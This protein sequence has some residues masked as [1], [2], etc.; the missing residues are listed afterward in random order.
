MTSGRPVH[1]IPVVYGVDNRFAAPLAASI[2]SAIAH[3]GSG[4][5]LAI[6][7]VDGGLTER[8][9]GRL[10]RSFEG[11]CTLSW[12]RPNVSALASLKVGGAITVATYY[13]LLIPGLLP[14]HAKAI[15]LDADVIVEHDLAELWEMA[16][17]D[18]HVLAAQDQGVRLVSGPYGLSNYRELGIPTDAKYFNAG[19][20]VLNL[21]RWRRDATADDILEYVLRHPEH[22]RFHD[23]DGLNAILWNRWGEIDP[24]WNQ[25]PQILQVQRAEDS[26]FDA[27]TFAQV[28]TDPYII[29][30]ASSEKPWRY[31]CRHPA[32]AKYFQYLDRTEF[33]GRRPSRLATGLQDALTL[34]KGRFARLRRVLWRRRTA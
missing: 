6:Y 10:A 13:R 21:T 18:R 32:T 34:Y 3:L 28:T 1:T 26:P 29:H 25:M 30:F 5:R 17:Q 33:R 4:H 27:G 9:R 16:L 19:V 24:R 23:Q 15:Y 2:E 12:L 11:R 7:V 14:E 22:I 31:G 8:N 20:L